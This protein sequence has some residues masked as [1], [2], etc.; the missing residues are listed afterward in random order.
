MRI[1]TCFILAASVALI[2][3]GLRLSVP[4][5]PVDAAYREVVEFHRTLN[6]RAS[7]SEP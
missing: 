1:S 2:G 4:V 5:T 7:A 3:V 6:P